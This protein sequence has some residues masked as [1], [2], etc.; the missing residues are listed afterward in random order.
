MADRSTL[1]NAGFGSMPELGR[2]TVPTFTDTN[3]R[4]PHPAVGA[5]AMARELGSTSQQPEVN[6]IEMTRCSDL[7]Q[8][9]T[10]RVDLLKEMAEVRISNWFTSGC[11]W[12][13]S[14]VGDPTCYTSGFHILTPIWCNQLNVHNSTK[15][16][17]LDTEPY[18]P[19]GSY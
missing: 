18:H 2:Q 17:L 7:H 5:P 15:E 9:S 19:I 3:P 4:D 14:D 8:E 10:L 16:F 6:Q 11:W 12:L 1:W 13:S